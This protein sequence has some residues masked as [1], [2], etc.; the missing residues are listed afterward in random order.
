M[1]NYPALLEEFAFYIPVE[2]EEE[3]ETLTSNFNF[4]MTFVQQVRASYA[5]RPEV[6]NTFLLLLKD[7]QME[8]VTPTQVSFF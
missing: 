5:D 4:A 7:Y 6:Y 2:K 8:K 3:K 1:A